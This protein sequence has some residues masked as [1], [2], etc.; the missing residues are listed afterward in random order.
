MFKVRGLIEAS[1]AI[2]EQ[3]LPLKPCRG[4]A[5]LIGWWYGLELAAADFCL[6][7]NRIARSL[8]GGDRPWLWELHK[9]R[10]FHSIECH[11]AGTNPGTRRSMGHTRRSSTASTF[12]VGASLQWKET[13]FG[14]VAA[15]HW[16]HI[17]FHQ[18]S[19]NTW[20]F[21]T[22][23]GPRGFWI[24]VFS[25]S[26]TTTAANNSILFSWSSFKEKM[27]SR[28]VTWIGFLFDRLCLRWV[29]CRWLA[30]CWLRLRLFW[31]WWFLG[32]AITFFLTC[33]KDPS[34]PV[35]RNRQAFQDML[36]HLIF[37]HLIVAFQ[38]DLQ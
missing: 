33:S 36:Q 22:I 12:Q 29:G 23:L 14:N 8:R 13:L 26:S 16:F 6:E 11:A 25:W 3:F 5:R 31:W 9:R 4:I 35:A 21:C 17:F 1:K 37:G 32:E 24:A 18:K 2:R 19:G 15:A 28:L 20:Q 34:L 27:P 7:F 38:G 30:F 10:Q